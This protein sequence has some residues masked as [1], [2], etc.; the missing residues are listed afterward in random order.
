M[1][2]T[3]KIGLQQRFTLTLKIKRSDKLKFD[4]A[5]EPF[6]FSFEEHPC[7]GFYCIEVKNVTIRKAEL[8]RQLLKNITVYD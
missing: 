3:I 8:I 5:M 7:A 1:A 2:H 4:K 6:P